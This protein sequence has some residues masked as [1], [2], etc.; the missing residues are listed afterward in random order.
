MVFRSIRRMLYLPRHH[1]N[2]A[3]NPQVARSSMSEPQ[4]WIG[5]RLR[6]REDPALLTGQGRYASDVSR[7]DMVHLA[8]RR[9]G[10]AGARVR[11]ID[12]SAASSMPGVLGVF[13]FGQ[14]GLADDFMPDPPG[15]QL[16][17][18]RPVLVQDTV[19]HEGEAVAAVVAERS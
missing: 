2:L 11:S 6:R 16:T 18:R 8:I 7:P 10:L 5:R 14:L 1:V 19:R 4:A 3:A 9:A 15:T 12:T 17:L 13:T